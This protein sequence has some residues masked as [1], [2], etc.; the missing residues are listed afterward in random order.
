MRAIHEGRIDIPDYTE[1]RR[2]MYDGMS[3]RELSAKAMDDHNKIPLKLLA[4]QKSS[5]SPPRPQVR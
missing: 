1:W 4:F 3:V 2:D 5:I